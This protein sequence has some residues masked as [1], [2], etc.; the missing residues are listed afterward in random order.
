MSKLQATLVGAMGFVFTVLL[1]IMVR[2]KSSAADAPNASVAVSSRLY[3]PVIA[4]YGCPYNSNESA[5]KV[6]HAGRERPSLS[7]SE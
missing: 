6:S 1:P 7:L 2:L 3:S 4:G 5:L